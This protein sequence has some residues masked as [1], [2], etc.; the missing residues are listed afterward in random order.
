MAI[1][2]RKGRV[3]EIVNWCKV[4]IYVSYNNKRSPKYLAQF[5][6]QLPVRCFSRIPL[7]I[8]FITFIV[9]T[10]YNQRH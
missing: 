2:A 1:Y 3:V 8:Y 5:H 4:Q 9:M 6:L 7:F 10:Y